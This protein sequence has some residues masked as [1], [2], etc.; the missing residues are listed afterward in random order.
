[1]TPINTIATNAVMT[2]EGCFDLPIVRDPEAETQTSYWKP[3]ADELAQLNAGVPVALTIFGRFH[4]PVKLS[5][6]E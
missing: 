5:V 4:P 1:M 6:G 3:D 2:G